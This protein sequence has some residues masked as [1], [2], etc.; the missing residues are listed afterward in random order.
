MGSTKTKKI[1]IILCVIIVIAIIFCTLLLPM[2][3]NNL[4]EK[5]GTDNIQSIASAKVGSLVNFGTYNLDYDENNGEEDITWQVLEKDNGKVLLIAHKCIDTI[6]YN[7]KQ[8]SVTWE[9]C[10]IREWLNNDFYENAFC[11]SEKERILLTKLPN[12]DD[13]YEQKIAGNDTDDKVFLLS[14]NEALKYFETNYSRSASASKTAIFHGAY[15]NSQDA[16]QWWWLRTPGFST[17]NASSVNTSGTIEYGRVVDNDEVCVRPVIW[18]D[19][20]F[21]I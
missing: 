8:I 1:V 5:K 2:I 11:N 6:P 12:I 10:S 17:Y 13:S 15:G 16:G 21:V 19:I 20:S 18:V 3:K 4:R 7:T 9:D 14:I